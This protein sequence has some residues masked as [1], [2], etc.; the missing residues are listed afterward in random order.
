M[1]TGRTASADDSLTMITC[2]PHFWKARPMRDYAPHRRMSC[3]DS[4]YGVTGGKRLTILVSCT[5]I[6]PY[7]L[8]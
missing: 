3:T 2:E 5:T 1:R 6:F 8:R 4:G 7:L